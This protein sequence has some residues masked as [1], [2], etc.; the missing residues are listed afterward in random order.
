MRP[1]HHPRQF[2]ESFVVPL[3]LTPYRA[4]FMGEGLNSV[5]RGDVDVVI[6]SSKRKIE[7]NCD[8]IFKSENWRLKLGLVMTAPLGL[9]ED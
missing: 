4:P 6:D 7:D 3:W 2:A 1:P 9:A 5:I 8:V